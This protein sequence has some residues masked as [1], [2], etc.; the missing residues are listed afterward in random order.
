[1]GPNRLKSISI[2]FNVAA[3]RVSGPIQKNCSLNAGARVPESDAY[4]CLLEDLV[5]SSVI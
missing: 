4:C 1:M 3:V 2:C 5:S